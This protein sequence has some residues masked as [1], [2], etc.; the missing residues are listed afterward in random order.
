MKLPANFGKPSSVKLK[1]KIDKDHQKSAML[2]I[3][4]GF[5]LSETKSI[6]DNDCK[7][8]SDFSPN[9]SANEM[10]SYL[11]TKGGIWK[12]L[13]VSINNGVTEKEQKNLIPILV[14]NACNETK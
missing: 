5:C 1:Q 12:S 4:D 8:I 2:A 14:K 13:A 6:T 7:N 3:R 11:N 9:S 10:I